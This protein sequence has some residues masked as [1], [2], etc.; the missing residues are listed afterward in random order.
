M[1]KQK[2]TAY[3]NQR[4]RN[5]TK[6]HNPSREGQ[7]RAV[8][9]RL[10][11]DFVLQEEYSVTREVSDFELFRQGQ[12][13]VANNIMQKQDEWMEDRIKIFDYQFETGYGK[14]RRLVA[15]TVFLMRSKNLGLPQFVMKPETI[16]NKLGSYL[17]MQQDIDF[18][19][20]PKFS[21]NYLLQGDDEDYIRFKMTDEIL[22]FFSRERGWHMEGVN[23]YLILYK[24]NQR[25]RANSIPQLYERGMGLFNILKED[26][27][28]T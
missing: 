4:N 15:Q 3:R 28:T 21:G 6:N 18:E 24:E 19:R 26:K 9:H 13:R 20:F 22:H 7:M 8:A 5:Q 1:S 14:S 23:Y 16:F 17:G 11:M 27:P 12:N 2:F 25:L 10:K